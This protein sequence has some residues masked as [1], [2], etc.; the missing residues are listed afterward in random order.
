MTFAAA[1][2]LMA[3]TV[4]IFAFVGAAFSVSAGRLRDLEAFISARGTVPGIGLALTIF[5][6]SMGGWILFSP[7]EVG[8]V[9]GVVGVVGYA[10]GSTIP[11]LMYMGL[12]ARL[13][14]LIP[15]GHSLVEFVQ[16]R[17]GRSMYFAT[18]AITAFYLFIVLSAEMTGIGLFVSLLSGT[19]M[20][21]TAGFVLVSTLVYTSLGGLRAS[22]FTDRLQSFLILPGLAA[23][24]VATVVL[25]GG[26][27]ELT[28]AAA[29]RDPDLVDWGNLAG[30]EQAVT[31]LL[32]IVSASLFNQG[33][34]QRVYAARDQKALRVG[35]GLAGMLVLPVLL[36]AGAFGLAA[37]GMGQAEVPSVA[38]L[39]VMIEA[40]PPWGRAGLLVLALV[41]V[42]S[43]ADT[44]L[45]ALASIVAVD[46]AGRRAGRGA[47]SPL[48][49]SRISAILI[50]VPVWWIASQGYSVLYLFLVADLICAAAVFPVFAGLFSTRHGERAAMIALLCGLV[51][52]AA[53][54]PDPAFTRGHLLWS[55]VAAVGA[56]GVAIAVGGF[57]STRRFDLGS[58][59]SAIRSFQS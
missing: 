58:L 25:I 40:L 50:A 3:V 19:P 37:V 13:R 26:P 1:L 54:F 5:A 56:S 44:V 24:V 36:V 9:F 20:W 12:G 18:L 53:L 59:S 10:L 32:A 49:A 21:V 17:Y 51:A 48:A 57:G 7:A 22:I 27:Q 8:V 52:G 45:N 42:M 11:L 15:E 46:L 41:L 2:V 4:G 33:N 16:A 30:W 39:N 43:S 6:S 28:A 47:S 35:F 55:F 14:R 34:W 31:L 38:F 29:D 23:L